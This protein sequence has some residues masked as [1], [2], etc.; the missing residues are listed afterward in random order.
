MTLLPESV[1]S[2]TL[3]ELAAEL[4]S[5]ELIRDIDQVQLEV[6]KSDKGGTHQNKSKK[7]RTASWLA[8]IIVMLLVITVASG[9]IAPFVPIDE[10]R[11]VIAQE[12]S[13]I[14]VPILIS[15]VAGVTAYYFG[16]EV[17]KDT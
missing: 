10:T 14:M 8:I 7:E 11:V 1:E 12:H 16:R 15:L 3:N 13:K 2:K 4:L 17:A 9:A 6:N 5:E